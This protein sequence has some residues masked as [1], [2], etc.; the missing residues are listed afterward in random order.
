MKIG[1][2]VKNLHLESK[3]TRTFVN[4]HSETT[5][6]NRV[7]VTLRTLI[8]IRLKW[9]TAMNKG[10]VNANKTTSIFDTPLGFSQNVE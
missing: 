5:P 7:L 6:T 4:N 10:E 9:Y 1:T 8:D 3:L 2:I